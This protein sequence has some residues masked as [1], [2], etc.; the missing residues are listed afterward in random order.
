[1]YN[2]A[3]KSILIHKTSTSAINLSIS[4]ILRAKHIVQLVFEMQNL[5]KIFL[6]LVIFKHRHFYTIE[7]LL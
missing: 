4:T 7:E 5:F 3:E 2:N 6:Q 1:M